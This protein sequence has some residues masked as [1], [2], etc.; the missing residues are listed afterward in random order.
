MP[1]F[2]EPITVRQLIE[3]LQ[4]QD[5]DAL[6]VVGRTSFGPDGVGGVFTGFVDPNP[7]MVNLPW[8]VDEAAG[9]KKA[10]QLTPFKAKR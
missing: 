3:V 2:D 9:F 8:L 1:V 7:T 6:V 5:P 10:V 4:K